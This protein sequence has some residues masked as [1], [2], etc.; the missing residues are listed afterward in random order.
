MKR[1]LSL[2]L[3][4]AMLLLLA[5]CGK[6]T[7]TAEGGQISSTGGETASTGM[8]EETRLT[9]AENTEAEN[10]PEPPPNTPDEKQEATLSPT[11]KTLLRVL[12]RE[13]IFVDEMNRAV[14]LDEYEVFTDEITG[15][16]VPA[17]AEEYTLVDLDGDGNNEMVVYVAPEYGA[18]LVFHLSGSTV[19]GFEFGVRALTDLKTDGSFIC[20][21]GAGINTFGVLRFKGNKY[22]MQELAYQS[23]MVADKV[24]RVADKPATADEFAA[25]Y[26]GFQ[27]KQG[28]TWTPVTG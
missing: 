20:S 5:A 13:Q 27:Q 7:D 10:L 11:D 23:D 28:V 17:T 14:Y 26:K 22:E 18:Y 16:G 9:S 4:L 15:I 19:Y 1:S 12:R 2:L 21:A 8:T 25:F 24:Y 6:K 3:A